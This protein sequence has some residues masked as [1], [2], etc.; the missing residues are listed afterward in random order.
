MEASTVLVDERAALATVPTVA[1]VPWQM[2]L[3][4]YLDTLSSSRTRLAYGR[5]VAEAM[6]ALGAACPS[7][8][9]PPALARYR[10]VLVARLDPDRPDRLRPATVSLKLAALRQFLTFCRLTGIVRLSKD[11]IGF[12]LKSPTA[13]VEKPYQVLNGGERVRLLAVAERHGPRDFALVALALGG[14]LRVSELVGARVGDFYLDDGGAWWLHVQMGKGRKDREVPLAAPVMAAV[15]AWIKSSGL[16]LRRK[17]DRER[18]VFST[19]QSPKMTAERARQLVKTLVREAG[20]Q[21]S[22]SPHSMRHTMAIETLRAGA[23]PVVV[24]RLLG[25][26]S[27]ATTQR[28]VD[29]LERADLVRWAF[30]PAK[31]RVG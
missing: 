8:L 26:A 15:Q 25:H 29:H 11:A 13:T 23:S 24:Q 31:M 5:A 9:E 3:E 18:Y 10:A 17:A 1:G 19:R 20:I 30:S 16:S 7:D 22:I 28:Y 12:V 4:T 14:G 21:K 6:R 27:L 2:A